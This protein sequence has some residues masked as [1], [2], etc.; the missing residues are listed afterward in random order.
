[1]RLGT[2]F[3]TVTQLPVKMKFGTLSLKFIFG[4]N[5]IDR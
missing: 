2:H 3:D 5:Q 1:M 4:N